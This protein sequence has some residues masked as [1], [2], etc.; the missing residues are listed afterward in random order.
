VPVIAATGSAD[1]G[2]AISFRSRLRGVHQGR[3]G[4]AAARSGGSGEEVSAGGFQSDGSGIGSRLNG[5]APG[6]GV[7]KDGRVGSQEDGVDSHE[8]LLHRLD[9]L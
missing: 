2:G 9:S 5:N 8:L 6:P 4:E 7:G 3:E 1:D